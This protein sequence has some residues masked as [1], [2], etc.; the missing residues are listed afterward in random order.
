[1][2]YDY[3]AAVSYW[4]SEGSPD[5]MDAD[6]NGIPCEWGS[7][8]QI[9]FLFLWAVGIHQIA[10]VSGTAAIRRQLLAGDDG[11]GGDT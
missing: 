7:L 3:T 5:R 4:T 1:M 10:G 8:Q 11:G 6:R 9:G 2:G